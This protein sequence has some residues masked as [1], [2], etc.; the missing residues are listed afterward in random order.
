MVKAIGAAT[1]ALACGLASISTALAV[2]LPSA[3]V[4]RAAV[5]FVYGGFA[6]RDERSLAAK[7]AID[8]TIEN[9]VASGATTRE[10]VK[11]RIY[12]TIALAM[13]EEPRS[14]LIA[15]W[16]ECRDSFAP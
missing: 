1:V 9:A 12:D 3:T 13:D 11:E 5:C 16:N 6:P 4:D 2:D 7:A 14:E 15:N 8:R 10:L